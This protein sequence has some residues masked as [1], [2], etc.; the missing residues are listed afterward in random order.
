MKQ[1]IIR[2]SPHQNGKVF[3]ILLAVSSLIFMVPFVLLAFASAPAQ[4]TPSMG[5]LV[6]AP[7]LYLVFGYVT[8]V[9]G[10]VLYNLLAPHLGGVE[11]E[12]TSIDA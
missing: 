1:Q 9:V 11:F 12:T 7:L 6:A 8:V 4:A 2:F 3:A 10:S 5:F